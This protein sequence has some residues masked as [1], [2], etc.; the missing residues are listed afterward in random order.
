MQKV[1]WMALVD[2]QPSPL[3]HFLPVHPLRNMFFGSA[4]HWLVRWHCDRIR[5]TVSGCNSWRKAATEIGIYTL[6]LCKRSYGRYPL[7]N[8][9]VDP[10]NHQFLMETSLP[11][12]ICQGPC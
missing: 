12:P 11:T 3:K 4:R 1:F 7:V 9:L 8:K 10:E 5:P 2:Y 6:W